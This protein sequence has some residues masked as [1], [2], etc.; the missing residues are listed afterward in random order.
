MR[1]SF[2][3]LLAAAAI[4]LPIGAV[5]AQDLVVGFSQDALT[6]DPANHRKRETE[7]IIRNIYD[8]VLTRDA[9]TNVVPELVESYGQIDP[10]TWELKLRRGV[11]FHD[12]SELTA[13]DVKFTFDRLAKEGAMG[14]QTSPRQSLLGPLQDVEVVDDHTARFKLKT[15]WPIL[16]AMLPFQ[17]V[18][19]KSFVE[20][21]GSD[22]LATEANGTGPFK[23]VEWRR[24]DAVIMERFDDY[25]GGSTEIPPVGP[26]K[27]ERVIFR[28][29]PENSSRVASLLAGDVQL[30]NELPVS[31]M[32]Q[33]ESNPGTQV[34]KVNGTRTFFVALNNAKPPLDDPRVRKA[35]NYA[36]DKQLIIDKVLSGTATPLSG[37]MSPDAFAFNPDLEPYAFD[38]EKAKALLAE[39]GHGDGFE[40]TLD[41]E[42][43]FKETA[44]AIAAL[45]GKAGVKVNVQ[46]WEGAVLTPIR[47]DPEQRKDPDLYLTSWGNGSLDPSARSS[48]SGRHRATRRRRSRAG[49]CAWIVP[50]ER[51]ASA[52]CRSRRAGASIPSLLRATAAWSWPALRA[53]TP[54]WMAGCCGLW[55]RRTRSPSRL[56]C[57]ELLGPD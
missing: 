50:A 16:P 7:T 56:N 49:S 32:G 57:G 41:T 20:R 28:V 9:A 45:L 5:D 14:G 54:T 47:R 53:G 22:A 6:L 30:I 11:K 12:G 42:G 18:V 39:A 40:V 21:V 33:V 23:L 19:S 15:P 4:A 52:S 38:L 29:I 44:E 43:A 36:L 31:A 27:V 3:P 46:V 34:M 37:V 51:S 1:T 17:E 24:G 55:G 25:Y 48:P 35:L 8:G 26:A 10:T 2:A 13:E